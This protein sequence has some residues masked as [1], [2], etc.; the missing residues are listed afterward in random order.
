MIY[1]IAVMLLLRSSVE[2]SV[3]VNLLWIHF[4]AN[5]W[6]S[7]LVRLLPRDCSN[8][9]TL[10]SLMPSSPASLASLTRFWFDDHFVFNFLQVAACFWPWLFPHSIQVVLG[11]FIPGWSNVMC[12]IHNVV[13]QKLPDGLFIF[14]ICFL[15][16][17]LVCA[18]EV[19]GLK[20]Q[21]Y[22]LIHWLYMKWC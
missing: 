17:L 1:M 14:T 13:F 2:S 12:G 22:F 20:I 5:S 7:S 10:S 15:S 21:Y 6:S 11:H 9:S 3:T 8:S 18:A 4:S 16:K 19:V